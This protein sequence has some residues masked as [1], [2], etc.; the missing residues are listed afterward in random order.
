MK[1][2][3]IQLKLLILISIYCSFYSCDNKEPER[4]SV[5]DTKTMEVEQKIKDSI[6]TYH[7]LDT[8]PVINYQKVIIRNAQHRGQLLKDFRFDTANPSKNKALRTL[9]RKELGYIR[10]GDTILIPDKFYD[11]MIAYSIFPYYYPSAAYLSKL[12]VVSTKWQSYA[13]YENGVLARF[14]AANTGKER[15]PSFPGRYALVWKAALRKSSL[16]ETWLMP[17]TW[18]FHRYA[19]NAF[20]KFDMPGYP[21]SHS[22]IRQFLDDAKWLFRWGEGAKYVNRI[23]VDM[24]GTPVIII[25]N[26]DFSQGRKGPW[27]KLNNNKDLS[28]QLPY[29]PMTVEEALIP[30]YQIPKDSRGILPNRQRYLYAEDTLR[31]R[32]VI[33]EKVK[34]TYSVN[35]NLIR[36][37]KE[38]SK[39]K[40]DSLK[41]IQ[42]NESNSSQ[43]ILDN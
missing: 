15:T 27:F 32:G 35:F 22:C 34:L 28:L 30:F 36:K 37:Q 13:C 29:D 33:R 26:Y 9:N 14:A 18:N 8:F 24:S 11:N 19:G 2:V 38:A 21:A 5:A 7:K 6:D 12:I 23:P 16:D 17:F 3:H 1:I 20:H 4:V 39:R 41:S 40:K 42:Q 10:V 31:A 25:D 43:Q